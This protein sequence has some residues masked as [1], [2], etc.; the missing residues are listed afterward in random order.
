[1]DITPTAPSAPPITQQAIDEAEQIIAHI[2]AL[3]NSPAFQWLSSHWKT[4]KD[5]LATQVLE[6]NKLTPE[7]RERVRF[8]YLT[9]KEKLDAIPRTFQTQ[10]EVLRKA[11]RLPARLFQRLI[12]PTPFEKP[13]DTDTLNPFAAMATG[14]ADAH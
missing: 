14:P 7:E 9:L 12:V 4:H 6:D 8:G 10:M 3:E 2:E 5:A 1:M 13:T 11:N